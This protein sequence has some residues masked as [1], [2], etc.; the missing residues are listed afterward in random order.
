MLPFTVTQNLCG[1]FVQCLDH[2][3]FDQSNLPVRKGKQC[4]ASSSL[5]LRLLDER[6][7]K[8]SKP[9]LL[10]VYHIS[11]IFPVFS[12]S[13]VINH[14]KKY[15]V[16]ACFCFRKLKCICRNSLQWCFVVSLKNYL[17]HVKHTLD[18][19]ACFLLDK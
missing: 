15:D 11:Y 9:E 1:D 16:A 6:Y 5:G 8:L 12:N 4:R 14:Y 10:I 13:S 19:M 18:S 7:S 3:G 17:F 2:L